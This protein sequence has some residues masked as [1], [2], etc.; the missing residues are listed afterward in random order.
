MARKWYTAEEIIG[1]L[2]TI[3]IELGKVTLPRFYRH[4]PK[5]EHG[6]IGGA[7]ASKHSTSVCRGI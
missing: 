3:E 5:G 1:Q 7:H 2:R 4:L 6:E